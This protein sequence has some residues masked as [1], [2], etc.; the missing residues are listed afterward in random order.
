MGVFWSSLVK[1][2]PHHSP[3]ACVRDYIYHQAWESLS[4]PMEGLVE[5]SG[6]RMWSGLFC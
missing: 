4:V 3:R 6:E 2:E 5:A 1:G